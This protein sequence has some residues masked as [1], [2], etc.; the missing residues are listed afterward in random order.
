MARERRK[1]F[2]VEWNSTA[3]VLGLDGQLICACV[4]SDLSDGGAK[5]TAVAKVIPDQFHLVI[6]RGPRG[7]RKCRVLWRGAGVIGVAFTD[8]PR[9][10][11][12][13]ETEHETV[14]ATVLPPSSASRLGARGAR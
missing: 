2:R 12:K 3:T 11:E 13:P 14:S 9:S 6:T 1:N 10:A 8:R 4:L 5:L 7:R